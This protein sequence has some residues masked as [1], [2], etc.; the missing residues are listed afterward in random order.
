MHAENRVA[1]EAM[2][3]GVSRPRFVGFRYVGGKYV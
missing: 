1:F 2:C 3:K